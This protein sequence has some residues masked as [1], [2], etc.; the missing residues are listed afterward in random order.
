MNHLPTGGRHVRSPQPEG[1]V[2]PHQIVS[3]ARA[4]HQFVAEDTF[5]A[6][7]VAAEGAVTDVKEFTELMKD[8]ESQKVFAQ[9]RQ[10][11][12]SDPADIKTWRHKD[13]PD[14]FSVSK[15]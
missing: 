1:R 15:V 14:W 2:P 3:T 11:E 4:N 9:A 6:F 8:E 13:N 5:K 12:Q 10:S 7:K